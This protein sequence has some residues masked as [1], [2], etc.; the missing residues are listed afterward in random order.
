MADSKETKAEPKKVEAEP[1]KVEPPPPAKLPP[2]DERHLKLGELVPHGKSLDARELVGM[3]TDGRAI[4]RGNA[5]RGRA[6]AGQAVP[7]RVPRLRDSEARVAG[8]AAEALAHLALAARPLIPQIVA[9]LDG[10]R[11]EVLDTADG[12]LAARP[13]FAPFA[14]SARAA[15]MRT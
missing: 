10:A 5:A 3:L 12:A 14:A 1:R 9:S 11:P 6:A 15:L 7:E 4:V 2:F 13:D 8:A